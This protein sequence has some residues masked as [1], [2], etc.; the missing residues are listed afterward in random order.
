[1]Y[2]SESSEIAISLIVIL[3][4]LFFHLQGSLFS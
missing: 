2:T 1:M 4:T 3:S